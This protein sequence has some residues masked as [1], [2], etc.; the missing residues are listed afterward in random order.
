VTVMTFPL[1]K[2]KSVQEYA[3]VHYSAAAKIP[4]NL[5]LDESAS[6]SDNFITA[7]WTLFGPNLKLPHPLTFPAP[8]PPAD[9][10]EPILVYGAGASAGQYTVQLLKLA[11]YTK[12]FVT[13]SAH[14]HA[15]L[16]GLGASHAFDYRN[17]DFVDEILTAA[18]GKI[19]TAVDIIA[20]RPSLDA[21]SKVVGPGSKVAILL[22]V[23]K[24]ETVTNATDSDMVLGIPDA[25]RAKFTGVELIPVATFQYQTDE[26]VRENLMP[27]ILPE[28]LANGLVKPNRIRL[29]KE[30]TLKERVEVGLDL[31]RNN[32]VSGEKI[33]V[34]INV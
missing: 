10:D 16:K 7:F 25:V 27:K 4:D 30:G 33:V 31:L 32:K 9:A 5:P 23:K 28:L 1:L 18:G 29:L 11:G 26:Y 22:P 24:G 3:I 6:L 17:P 12:I 34:E 20:A 15:H 19:K 13:A 21:I 14:N 2:N 8:V